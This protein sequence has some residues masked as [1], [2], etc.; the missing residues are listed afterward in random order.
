[1]PAAPL[2]TPRRQ[3]C[4]RRHIDSP[5]FLVILPTLLIFLFLQRYIYKGFAQGATK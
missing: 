1:V 5:A 3:G 2:P 4:L